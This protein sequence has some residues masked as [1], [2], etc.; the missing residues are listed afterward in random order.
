M[1]HGYIYDDMMNLVLKRN[2]AING[3]EI[4]ER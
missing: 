3:K 1:M 4:E 2:E